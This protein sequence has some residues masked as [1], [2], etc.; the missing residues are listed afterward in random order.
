[1]TLTLT[2][3]EAR[4]LRTVLVD[5]AETFADE[6]AEADRVALANRLAEAL[7]QAGAGA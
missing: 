2:D 7:E 4:L 1:L 6:D 3:S 5:F